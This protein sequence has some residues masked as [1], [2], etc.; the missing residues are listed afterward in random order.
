MPL[1]E[2]GKETHE[3]KKICYIS[4]QEFFARM[5]IMKKNLN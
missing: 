1:T 2:E 3:N 4:E 5:K